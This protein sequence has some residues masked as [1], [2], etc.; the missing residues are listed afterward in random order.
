[1]WRRIETG[2]SR[3]SAPTAG[4]LDVVVSWLTQPRHAAIGVTVLVFF[5]ITIGVIQGGNTAHELARDRYLAAVS[6]GAT[7]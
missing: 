3:V 5:G 1:M 7:H 6:P 4:W 2:D